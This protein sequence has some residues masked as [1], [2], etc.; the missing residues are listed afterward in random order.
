MKRITLNK[1]DLAKVLRGEIV[2][3]RDLQVVLQDAAHGEFEHLLKLDEGERQMLVL[4]MAELALSRPGWDDALRRIVGR[5]D[6]P[7]TPM[8]ESLKASNADRVRVERGPLFPARMILKHDD[9]EVRRWIHGIN[10]GDPAPSGDFLYQFARAVCRAD[11]D[12]YSILRPALLALKVKFPKY[13]FSGA[14]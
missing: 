4:A 8:Y 14:L 7:G 11:C 13:R 6:N 2:T 5:I 10:Q 12:N 1:D 9:E 3:Q